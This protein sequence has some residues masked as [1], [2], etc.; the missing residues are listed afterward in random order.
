MLKE[1]VIID[2]TTPQ[3]AK[4]A[5]MAG[6]C[7]VTAFEPGSFGMVVEGMG[8]GNIPTVFLRALFSHTMG[9]PLKWGGRYK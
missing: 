3:Q 7:T 4:I 9:Y 8:I 1:G 6:A 2:I 5:E